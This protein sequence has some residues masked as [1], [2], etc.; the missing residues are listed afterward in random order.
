MISEGPP[1]DPSEMEADID[2]FMT[3]AK[4]L[5]GPRPPRPSL[6][7]GA[8][9][10]PPLPLRQPAWASPLTCL[11]APPR[12]SRRLRRVPVL[13]GLPAV[14][15][16][17]L[18]CLLSELLSPGGAERKWPA[19]GPDRGQEGGSDSEAGQPQ[20]GEAVISSPSCGMA[21]LEVTRA[22]VFSAWPGLPLPPPPQPPPRW[23]IL[24]PHPSA[25][26]HLSQHEVGGPGMAVVSKLRLLLTNGAF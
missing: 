22:S 2:S 13:S 14:S 21:S 20:K 24:H 23:L 18:S 8:G 5:P 26:S 3:H 10:G 9:P 17:D 6:F 25:N 7:R 16:C 1:E 11:P 15:L 4:V 12:A 19:A